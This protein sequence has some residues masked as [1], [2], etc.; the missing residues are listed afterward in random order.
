MTDTPSLPRSPIDAPLL[1]GRTVD[2]ERL[3]I[4]RHRSG[5]WQ[6]VGH[7]HSPW[8][9]IPP[10][11]FDDEDAF[12][13]WLHYRIEQKD[14]AFYVIVDKRGP[15]PEIAG[16]YILLQINPAMGTTELGLMYGAALS[17][18]I[19]G[20]EAFFLMARYIFETLGYRRLEWRCNSTHTASQRTAIRFGFTLEGVLRQTGWVKGANW[21]NA[22][23]SILDREWPGIAAR[24]V[25]WLAPE[26]FTESGH[27]IKALRDFA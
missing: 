2:L 7:D 25:A 13:E 19:G 21:D 15:R 18:Q 9:R 8:S 23:L 14:S 5:L 16:F 1:T 22:V 6:A 4:E 11:P 17:R 12:T 27:Q 20:T 26:N 24:L 10:G 3:D